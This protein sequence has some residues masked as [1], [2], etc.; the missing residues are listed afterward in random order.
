MFEVTNMSNN[1]LQLSDGKSLAPGASRKLKTVGDRERNYGS[2]GWL[3]II[4][5]EKEPKPAEKTEAKK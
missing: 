3:T 5:E 2:R 4:E 1:P